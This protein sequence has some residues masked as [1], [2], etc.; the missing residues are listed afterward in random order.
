MKYIV[1][2]LTFIT[3]ISGGLYI[4]LSPALAV[5]KRPTAQVQKIGIGRTLTG[6]NMAS[7]LARQSAVK[8]RMTSLINLTT[9][10]E[11]QFD[12]IAQR[13]IDYYNATL[14]PNG[15]IVPN[16]NALIS[17]IQTRKD[18]IQAALNTA[19]ANLNGFNCSAN[20]PKLLLSQYR[21]NMQTVKRA[22]MDYKISIKNLVTAIRLVTPT[23]V[24]NIENNQ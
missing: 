7:C 20:D 5:T 16:Y 22:L 19:Q 11:R 6:T 4:Q 3:L 8:N 14:V 23:T 24:N 21:L 1:F 12:L 13:S 15:N 2:F 18:T 10:M 9:T 17:N